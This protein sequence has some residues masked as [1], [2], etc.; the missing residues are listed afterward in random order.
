[1]SKKK[2]IIE[3]HQIQ[4]YPNNQF[5]YYLHKLVSKKKNHVQMKHMS[6]LWLTFLLGKNQ[7]KAKLG[8]YNL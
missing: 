1:M 2:T 8:T 6:E 5:K 4:R 7:E 3:R